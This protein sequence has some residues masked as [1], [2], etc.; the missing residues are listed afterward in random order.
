MSLLGPDGKE[1]QPAQAPEAR[2]M[3]SRQE[4]FNMIYMMV[5][6]MTAEERR[7][8]KKS[9]RPL[10]REL[11]FKYPNG[12]S[13]GDMR[14]DIEK[15]ANAVVPDGEAIQPENAEVAAPLDIPVQPEGNENGTE[16]TPLHAGDA[17]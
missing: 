2:R 16:V 10:I 14:H 12:M 4:K 15:A 1:M 3:P 17:Q 9:L 8:L 7:M 5:T 13:E 11:D 6:L